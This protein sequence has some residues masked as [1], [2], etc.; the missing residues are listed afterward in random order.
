MMLMM[1]R[2]GCAFNSHFRMP[3][4]LLP[5]A[6]FVGNSARKTSG[7]T[8]TTV[9]KWEKFSCVTLKSNY[10]LKLTGGVGVAYIAIEIFK[11]LDSTFFLMT[12]QKERKGGGPPLKLTCCYFQLDAFGSVLLYLGS[13]GFKRLRF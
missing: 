2:G 10:H 5:L 6:Q 12:F 4:L 1:M 9:C 7:T 13:G 8:T 3:R 11:L